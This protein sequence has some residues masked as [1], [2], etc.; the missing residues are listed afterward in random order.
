M[1]RYKTDDPLQKAAERFFGRSGE[2]R[3][4]SPLTLVELFSVF[5]RILERV[6]LSVIEREIDDVTR[7]EAVVQASLVDCGLSIVSLPLRAEWTL[8][9]RRFD[10]PSEYAEARKLAPHLRLKTLDILHVAYSSLLLKSGTPIGEFVTGDEELVTR[11]ERIKR[12]I[13]IRVVRPA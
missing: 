6:T 10:V 3:F 12:L 5:S 13:G 4:V 8:A 2:T 7:L 1:A 9:D 11:S